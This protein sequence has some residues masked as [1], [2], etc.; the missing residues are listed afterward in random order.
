V[1]RYGNA[2]AERLCAAILHLESFQDVDPQHPLGGP[3]GLKDV[4]CSKDGKTWIA[5]AYF[6]PTHPTFSEIRT[7][8]DHDFAGVAANGVQAFAFVVNQPLSIAEREKLQSRT[9]GVP[10]E[11]YH[12]ER[13]RALL[14]AP[15]GCGIR[16]EYLRI[17]MTESEQWS[18]WSTMNYDVV[19]KLSENEVRHDAQMKSVQDTLNKILAQTTAIEM[20]LHE[21]PSSLQQTSPP[22]ESVEMP[23]ASFSAATVCW[24]HR[25][26][27]EELALPEAVR[28]RFRGV[29][30]WIGSADSSRETAR[31]VPPPPEAVPRLV[32]EWLQWWHEQHRALRGQPK[33][34]VVAGLAKLH[35][36]FLTIHPFMDAN[37]RVARSIA[38]QAAR[39]LL[40][41]R[42]GGEFIEDAQAYYAALA[43]ADKGD[44]KPLQD[45]IKAA[46]Q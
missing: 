37:G 28:G 31:Y 3:D 34:D 14:D 7:K 11:I 45:R 20:N 15:K 1:L 42:I 21:N 32:D 27:T 24:L 36:R 44:L 22:V 26:L 43:A 6:P 5:A 10:V 25:L 17:P 35:H 4:R 40:N 29:Q 12:L 16:L 19:R 33:E 41:Q 23:T 13:I 46:L 9:G 2:Q 39:E 38:D 8:F 18:F 30:V